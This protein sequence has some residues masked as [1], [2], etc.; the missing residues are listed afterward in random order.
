MYLSS[1][2]ERKQAVL[3]I[4]LESLKIAGRECFHYSWHAFF[5]VAWTGQIFVLASV[6]LES[7]APC[8]IYIYF[9]IYVYVLLKRWCSNN[10]DI[11]SK[12]HK[13]H[14]FFKLILKFTNHKIH[15]FKGYNSVTF[16]IFTRLYNYHLYLVPKHFC[17]PSKKH[18]ALHPFLWQPLTHFQSLWICL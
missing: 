18:S 2:L 17:H 10:T 11:F 8:W 13:P 14:S 16:S 6:K 1:F 7:S 12:S 3:W 5:P 15:P 4:S 9:Y